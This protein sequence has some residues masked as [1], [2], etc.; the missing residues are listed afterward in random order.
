LTAP[1]E[2]YVN[3]ASVAQLAWHLRLCDQF[4]VPPLSERVALMDYSAKLYE[5]AERFEAWI[6]TTLVGLLAGYYDA[7]SGVVAFITSVSVLKEWQGRGVAS[8]LVERSIA[9]AQHLGFELIELQVAV[10]NDLAV[11]L[12]RKHGFQVISQD[13][14]QAKMALALKR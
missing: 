3:R 2:I 13:D 4:F 1:L 12:Y 14:N 7:E 11:R 10:Q 5:K 9:H 8:V 6:D